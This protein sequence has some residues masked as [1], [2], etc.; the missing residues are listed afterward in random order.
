MD[1]RCGATHHL[2]TVIML[3]VPLG[4]ALAAILVNTEGVFVSQKRNALGGQARQ[5]K[6]KRRERREGMERREKR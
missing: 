3:L 1:D 5:E 2:K 6:R 4:A